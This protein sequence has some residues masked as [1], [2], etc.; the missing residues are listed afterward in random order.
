MIPIQVQHLIV[1]ASSV[2][3]LLAVAAGAPP[4]SP[5]VSQQP[6]FHRRSASSFH[7]EPAWPVIGWPSDHHRILKAVLLDHL[8]ADLVLAAR[9]ARARPAPERPIRHRSGR[10]RR[11]SHPDH[12]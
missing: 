7:G 3:G 1:A 10:Y 8:G 4:P 5:H 12:Q 11:H 9:R 2:V 6:V